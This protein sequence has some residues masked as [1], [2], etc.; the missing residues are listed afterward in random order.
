MYFAKLLIKKSLCFFDN[1]LLWFIQKF[2]IDRLIRKRIIIRIDGG[3]CSQIHFY[4]IGRIFEKKGYRVEYDLSWYIRTFYFSSYMARKFDL[5]DL[6]PD[7]DFIKSPWYI[8]YIYKRIYYYEND[9]FVKC[10]DYFNC[11]PPL[12]MGGHYDI[13]SSVFK[14]LFYEYVHISTSVLDNLNLQI[15]NQIIS[16]RNSVAIHVR[17]G[18]LSQF[19]DYY[20]APATINYFIQAVSLF[21][22]KSDVFF[23]IFS[24]ETNWVKEHLISVLPLTSKY[25]VVDINSAKNGYMDLI[26]LSSCKH[27]ITSKG[28]FGKYGALINYTEETDVILIDDR[29]E[30]DKWGDYFGK[31]RWIKP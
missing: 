8:S 3:I 9:N 5:L 24:D 19:N 26:L 17:R 30:H 23:Y 2:N 10:Y 4:I 18:D 25:L 28:S 29:I 27:F 20:G 14:S 6:I 11:K 31:A 1:I 15:Y 22:N 13:S 21:L 16:H 7:L 12:Y